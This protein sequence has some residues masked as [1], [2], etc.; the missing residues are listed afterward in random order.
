MPQAVRCLWIA[1]T[2]RKRQVI[3]P[4]WLKKNRQESIHFLDKHLPV[5]FK[6]FYLRL[7]IQLSVSF[8]DNSI[9]CHFRI[10]NIDNLNG[11]VE[12]NRDNNGGQA[13][14]V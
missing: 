4:K 1:S 2:W 7:F 12:R 13:M 6:K 10:G 9:Y 11:F 14:F 5:L 3:Y 8:Q